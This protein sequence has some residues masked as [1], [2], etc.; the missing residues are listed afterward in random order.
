MSNL[1]VVATCQAGSYK[2]NNACPICDTD[3]YSSAGAS[4]CTP[5]LTNYHITGTARTDH[6]SS[7]DCKIACSG[8]SYIKTANDTSCTNV[9]AGNWAAASTIAQGSKGSVTACSSGLTTIGYGAGADE[10]GDCGRKFHAGEGMLYLRST[11]KT[12][13]SLNVKVGGTVFYGNMEETEKNMSDGVSKKLK[14]KDGG[15]VYYVH[16]DSVN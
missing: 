5:C 1:C 6:D 10:A 12:N 4:S 15:T 3:K 2:S 11:K 14:V 9:G 8:G 7:T 13:P 16:D